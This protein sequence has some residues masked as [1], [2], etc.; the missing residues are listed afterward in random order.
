MIK[1]VID[2]N[3]YIS[4]ILFSGN[5]RIIL[6]L[7]IKGK[8]QVYISPDILSE[9]KDVLSKKKFSFSPNII[10]SIIGE[11]ESITTLIVPLKK[12]N[13]VTR[14]I[15]DNIIV[16]C[17]IESNAEFIITGDNDLLSLKEFKNVKIIKPVDFLEL[18]EHLRLAGG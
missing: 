3:I 1:V 2:S 8:I 9:L 13:I 16:D 18:Y 4:G 7:A 15:D 14:D 10:Q 11:I 12:H 6:D 5:P 17:A